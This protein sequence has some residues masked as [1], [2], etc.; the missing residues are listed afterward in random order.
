MNPRMKSAGAAAVAAV[1]C[2]GGAYAIFRLASINDFA[3]QFGLAT[4]LAGQAL[5]GNLSDRRGNRAVLVLTGILI[6]ILPILWVFA[7][8]PWHVYLINTAS[9]ILWAGYNLASFNMLLELSPP[10]QREGGV[11]LYQSTVSASAVLGPLLGGL[12]IA[13]A[14][15]HAAFILSGAGRIVGSILFIVLVRPRGVRAGP[16]EPV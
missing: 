1:V 10:E 15:Y 4:G 16:S 2:C 6:P 14:G 3:N 7:R 13:T 8:V 9:G 5:F 11:A 12:L